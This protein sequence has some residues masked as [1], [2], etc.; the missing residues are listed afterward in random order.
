[1][2]VRLKFLT[3]TKLG[4][5]CRPIVSPIDVNIALEQAGYMTKTINGRWQAT[6]KGQPLVYTYAVGVIE[7]EGSGTI[8][9]KSERVNIVRSLFPQEKVSPG[10][11]TNSFDNTVAEPSEIGKQHLQALRKLLKY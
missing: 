3:A 10:P 11:E 2:A 5:C 4:E 6:E 8:Y 1:M 9:W 7:R